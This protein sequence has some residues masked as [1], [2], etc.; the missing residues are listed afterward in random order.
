MVLEME[1]ADERRTEHRLQYRWPVR[2]N[3]NGENHFFNGQI[4]DVS[5]K[6]IAFLCHA[7]Q[8]CFDSEQEIKASFGVPH[9]G[10]DDSFDTILF[11]R[12]GHVCRIDKPSSQVYRI[13]MQFASPLFFKPGEQGINEIDAQ[14]RLNAKNFSVIKAEE[15]ARAYNE[16]L[17]KA[18]KQL[19]QYAQAKAKIEEQLKAEIEDSA[20]YEAQIRIELAERIRPYRRRYSQIRGKI[21]DQRKRA[22][23]I[24][25]NCG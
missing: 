17:A 16:A 4:V 19:T 15:T 3:I 13:A 6:G 9:F 7:D 21:A 11:E 25:R 2:F 20:R 23:G 5:S 12:I 10:I 8:S 24:S 18:Q 22:Y 1:K 14:Q